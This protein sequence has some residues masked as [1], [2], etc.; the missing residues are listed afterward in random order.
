MSESGQIRR[1]R[2]RVPVGQQSIVRLGWLQLR[3]LAGPVVD[4][5]EHN[6]LGRA[7]RLT[8]GNHLAITNQAMAIPQAYTLYSYGRYSVKSGG[9]P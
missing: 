6:R 2:L 4:T 9:G 1:A 3:D 5:A 8:G 7:Q